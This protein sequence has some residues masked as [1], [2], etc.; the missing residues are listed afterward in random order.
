MLPLLA[1]GGVDTVMTHRDGAPRAVVTGLG[2]VSPIGLT[3]EEFWSNLTAGVSGIDYI[4]SF[5]ASL[6]TVKIAGEV[7]GFEP[8]TYMPHKESRRMARFSQFAVAV[9]R[10]A[11]QDACLEVTEENAESIAVVMNTGSGGV[12]TVANEEDVLTARGPG[13]VSAFFVPLMSPNMASAQPS[14]QLGLRGPSMTSVAACAAGS[15]AMV[16]ALRLIRSGD[17]DVVIAGGTEACVHPLAVAGFDNM[18][19]L[20]RRNDD[21]RSASRPFD[22]DRDG[23]VL[24]EGAA[25]LVIE[26]EDH[27]RRRGAPL[28]CELA[29]GAITADAYHLTAPSPDGEGAMLA[30][31]RALD[32]ARLNRDELDYIAAHGTGTPLN[33]AAETK[34]IKGVFGERAY[35]IPV[36]SNKSMI[37]HLCGAAGAASAVACVLAI[38]RGLLPPT[39]NL[40]TPD[41]E[42][43]L[44]YVPHVVREQA[45]QTAM[46]NGFGFG[47][48]NAVAAFRAI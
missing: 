48:Q 17:A 16:E 29:G 8:D 34:A 33:D 10:L 12:T 9:A 15:M 1:L 2:I 38:T 35:G 46:C 4:T 5:D 20:S 23:F 30:M 3:I 28:L 43:D 27:A 18:R 21:P 31:S 37:G 22:R 19:A 42:C 41:P 14:I 32:D 26:R 13:R 11:M 40:D 6:H 45:I 47:G 36:S 24:S 7:K 39:I 25:A 44:D